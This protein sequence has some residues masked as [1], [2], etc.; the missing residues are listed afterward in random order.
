LILSML[1][2]FVPFAFVHDGSGAILTITEFTGSA[3]TVHGPVQNEDNLL[4]IP[5]FVAGVKSHTLA[6]AWKLCRSW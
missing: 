2:T 3:Q 5:P 4:A 6:P 1:T